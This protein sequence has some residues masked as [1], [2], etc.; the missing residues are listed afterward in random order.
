M[1]SQFV[2]RHD[3]RSGTFRNR[4]SIS[5][6]IG[7]CVTDQDEVALYI[8]RFGRGLRIPREKGVDKDFC[9]RS[10]DQKARMPKILNGHTRG[11][12]A[13][14]PTLADNYKHPWAN[15]TPSPK[16]FFGPFFMDAHPD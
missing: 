6:M 5:V 14:I 12:A 9:F 8:L 4:Y 10:R 13:I 7:M 1:Q 3:R 11:H 2:N 15:K 16:Q